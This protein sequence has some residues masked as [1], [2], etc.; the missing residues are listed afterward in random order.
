MIAVQAVQA[1]SNL[2]LWVYS[3]DRRERERERERERDT[4]GVKQ[5]VGKFC[6]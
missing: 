4:C 1:V 2:F 5:I 6:Y 3:V